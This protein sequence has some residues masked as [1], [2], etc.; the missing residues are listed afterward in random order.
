MAI[1]ETIKCKNESISV[2][3]IRI[4]LLLVSMCK[5]CQTIGNMLLGPKES[6]WYAHQWSIKYTINH[7]WSKYKHVILA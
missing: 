6:W 2:D 7:A 1:S 5:G 3:L 4:K